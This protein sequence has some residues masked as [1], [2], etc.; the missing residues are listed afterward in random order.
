LTKSTFTKSVGR[1]KN[2]DYKNVGPKNVATCCKILTK[3]LEILKKKC[4]N[5]FGKCW[6][7]FNLIGLKW[8]VGKIKNII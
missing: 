5:N 6:N 8:A 4:C 2:V 3:I 7:I 1:R